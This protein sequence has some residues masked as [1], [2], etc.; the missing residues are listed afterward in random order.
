MYIIVLNLPLT[1]LSQ[2][3]V[4]IVEKNKA[5]GDKFHIASGSQD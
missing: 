4:L 2:V 5:Q 3:L 1:S